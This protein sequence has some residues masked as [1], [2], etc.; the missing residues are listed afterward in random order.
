MK[1][2]THPRF[3]LWLLSSFGHVASAGKQRSWLNANTF[4]EGEAP[5]GR[6]TAQFLTELHNKLYVFGGAK[7]SGEIWLILTFTLG[8]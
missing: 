8:S 1:K 6:A 5:A 3:F 7:G 4:V 2:L